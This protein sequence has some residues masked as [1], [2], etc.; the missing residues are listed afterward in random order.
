MTALAGSSGDAMWRRR[1]TVVLEPWIYLSPALV[2]I[3]TVLV[4]PLIIG[5]SYSLWKFSAFKSQFAG[6]D[7]YRT[8]F[9]DHVFHDALVNTV[10]WTVG[11]LFFQFF[12]GLGL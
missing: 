8:L 6:L 2:I 5:I 4:V 12:L 7:Q 1:W 10:W 9:A 11:S 3:V